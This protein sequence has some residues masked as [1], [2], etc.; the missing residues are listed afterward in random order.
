MADVFTIE[1]RS[2]LMGRIKSRG[3]KS[4]EEALVGIFREHRM[5]GWRRNQPLFGKPDFVF[6][7]A[8]VCVFVDGCFWHGCPKCYRNPSSNSAY[9]AAKIERNR[10]RDKKVSKPLRHDGW[11]V[12]RVWEHELAKFNRA[13]LLRRLTRAIWRA[14]SASE[15]ESGPYSREG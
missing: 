5:V 3:N 8:K 11:R 13:N 6:R 15:A 14:E 4:T 10:A 2:Q 12:L 1:K 7:K 9:W